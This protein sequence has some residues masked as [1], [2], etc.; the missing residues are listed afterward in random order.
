MLWENR[1]KGKL[2][3]TFNETRSYP[4][5]WYWSSSQLDDGKAWA[6]RFAGGLPLFVYKGFD[7]SLRCVR[8]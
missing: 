1:N 3:G 8:G 2:K 7:L 4:A 5:G 6:E